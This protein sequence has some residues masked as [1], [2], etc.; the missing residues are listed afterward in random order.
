ML[1]IYGNVIL[2]ISIM[3][4]VRYLVFFLVLKIIDNWLFIYYRKLGK[5]V[6]IIMK[7]NL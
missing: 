6:L 7:E 5:I 1:E 3:S 4:G 2:R